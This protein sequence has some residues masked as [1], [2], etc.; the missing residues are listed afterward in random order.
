MKILKKSIVLI[1][2]LFSMNITAQNITS[3]E[4]GLEI[5]VDETT[6]AIAQ[7]YY[8]RASQAAGS[9]T[10]NLDY[11]GT[12]SKFYLEEN[13]ANQ[14]DNAKIALAMAEYFQEIYTDVSTKT[15]VYNNE[16]NSGRFKKQEFLVTEP[17]FVE[18]ELQNETKKIQDLTCYK[19][20]GKYAY[21]SSEGKELTKNIIAW[22]APELS[23]SFGPNGFGGLPGL[24]LELQM[25]VNNLV[26]GAKKITFGSSQEDFSLPTE[27]KA[28]TKA[29]FDEL[30]SKRTTNA[31]Y[32]RERTLNK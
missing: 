30:T 28:I 13:I 25:D 9:L 18:W 6:N 22:Y 29:E 31:M 17:M 7:A 24:I 10:F 4:Y 20:T 14:E 15:M 26:F 2:V 19:A 1:A 12:Q 3:V 23:S 5:G 11:K 21:K 32:M 8:K 27:G 16:T